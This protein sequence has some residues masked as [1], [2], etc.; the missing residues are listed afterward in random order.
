MRQ[1]TNRDDLTRAAATVFR[2]SGFD[3]ARMSDVA[4]EAGVA[5]GTVYLHVESKEQLLELAAGR[6]ADRVRSVVGS[7]D[8]TGIGTLDAFEASFVR[9]YAAVFACVVDDPDGASLLLSTPASTSTAVTTERM[10]LVADAEMLTGAYLNEAIARG[11]VRPLPVAT[12]ARAI[13]GIVL[14]TAERTVLGDNQRTEL[15]ELAAQLIDFE[16]WGCAVRPSDRV[17]ALP[18]DLDPTDARETA[19]EDTTR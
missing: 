13:V 18:R 11:L 3:R 8:W 15:D 14:Y 19:Q 7:I 10:S 17:D 12:V 1:R 16:L 9:L 5:Q 2:R 4:R 6:F